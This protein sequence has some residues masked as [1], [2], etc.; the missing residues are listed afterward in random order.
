MKE[1][2]IGIVVGM[3][4]LATTVPVVGA[5][6]ITIE[7]RHL[8]PQSRGIE[9]NFTYDRG[10]FDAFRYTVQTKDK[11]YIC[12]GM[13]EETN[14][15]YILLLKL[16][17]NGTEEW[18]VIN[19]DLNG[20]YVDPYTMDVHPFLILQAQDGGFLISGLSTISVDVQGQN[21]WT[22]AGFLWKTTAT[23]STEW[24]HHYYNVTELYV[25]LIYYSLEIPGGFVSTG[26]RYYFDMT[27]QVT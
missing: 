19:Y 22:T 17:A 20:T 3:L 5:P 2:Q 13:T 1:I 9:W 16:S 4:L 21:I 24:V 8:S 27:G 6:T 18:H 23:G 14:R 26:S 7:E 15:F 12:C 10:E 25:D 11:G